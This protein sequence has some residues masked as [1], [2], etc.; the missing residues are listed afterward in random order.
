MQINRSF[1][2]S[3]L[4][5]RIFLMFVA[6]A[7]LPIAGLFILSFTQVNKQ[8]Y[9]QSHK[10]LKQ[11]AKAH[12]LSVYERLLFLEE[13]MLLCV[14][15]MNAENSSDI[16]K[17]QDAELKMRLTD[18]FRGFFM[19]QPGKGYRSFFG[20]S[21]NIPRPD[22]AQL[23][24]IVSGQTAILTQYAPDG[25]PR[26]F[27]LRQINLKRPQTAFLI[28]EV[29]SFYLW[30]GDYENTLPPGVDVCVLDE[31]QQILFSS[32]PDAIIPSDFAPESMTASKSDLFEVMLADEKH[33]ASRWTIFLK[34]KFLLHGWTVILLQS[35]T[36]VLAPIANF[37][38][39]FV[40]V[41]LMALWVVLL[42]SIRF[43]RRSLGPLELLKEG[44]R[45]IARTDFDC[46]VDVNSQ[47]EFEEL[48]DSFNQMSSRLSRQF[49]TLVTK[50]EI[51]RA[52]LSS[53]KTETIVKTVIT[54]MRDCFSFDAISIGLV[55]TGNNSKIQMFTG[56]GRQG[57]EI[58]NIYVSITS[59]ELQ[60]LND[61][62]EH[63]FIGKGQKLPEYLLPLS[64]RGIYSLLVLPIFLKSN[65]AAILAFGPFHPESQSEEELPLA[66]QI[67]DQVAVALSNSELMAE[68]KRLNWGTLKAL[69][70][71]VDAKSSWTAGHSE[72]VATLALQIGRALNLDASALE[73][74][75][76][77][78]LLHDIGKLGV[79][80]A[81]LD[82]PGA[83][84]DEEFGMI[85][86]HSTLGA[87]ILEP[88]NAYAE[89]IPMVLQHHERFDGKGYPD[90][91]S[92][93]EIELGAR[94]LAVADVFDALKSDR[95]YREGWS[96]ERVNELIL[97]EGGRQFDPQVV[98]AFLA[99]MTSKGVKAA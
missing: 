85:K 6:C 95:P 25:W 72:R 12:G 5:Q 36:D 20:K 89:I 8:L 48:A 40:L 14:A 68:L 50:A 41:V 94:I 70:R 92:G 11:S 9:Q 43:I 47:D 73:N 64:G 37:Q 21:K 65:L 49:K 44:T 60:K 27:L 32:L 19:Y 53:L 71:A 58:K 13:E 22:A 16:H 61:N 26:I 87:R 55:D 88:I 83:L 63:L 30:G 1:F 4:G 51:D 76:R 86:S 38:K 80:V 57:S 96:L 75:H 35:K 33:L 99:I 34:P 18:R 84:S 3:K 23:Q 2:R 82:K 46:Q 90:G 28:G 29:N 45:R 42:L 59:D 91:L 98:E 39:M 66:R 56:T 74:L 10:R 62:P 52:I 24:H 81:V 67:A 78:A 54:R 79:P 17:I 15:A 77:A 69:A 7:L 31:S 97:N 93:E